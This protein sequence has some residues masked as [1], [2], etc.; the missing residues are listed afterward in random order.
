[1][2]H[3]AQPIHSTHRRRRGTSRAASGL[4][5]L[6]LGILALLGSVGSASAATCV[7]EYCYDS[8]GRLQVALLCGT[9][10]RYT[11]D[12]AGNLI[13]RTVSAGTSPLVC[14]A[15]SDGLPDMA[16]TDT[17]TFASAADTG[18]D[19]FLADTDGDGLV[20][21]V[22]TNTGTFVSPSDTGSD[23]H[24]SDTDDDGVDDGAEVTAGSDPNVAEASV[25]ALG[26]LG[27]RLLMG[28]LGVSGAGLAWRLRRER[29]LGAV[30]LLVLPGLTL[31]APPAHAA[32][33]GPG[34]VTLGVGETKHSEIRAA[35]ADETLGD[36]SYAVVSN[37]AP[38]TISPASQSTSQLV[39]FQIT[40]TGV[41]SGSAQFGWSAPSGVDVQRRKA[42]ET[43]SASGRTPATS[44][45]W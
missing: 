9:E 41:G 10:Y 19:P 35:A 32:V 33:C 13:E 39:R 5:A 8:I 34:A 42:E 44:T 43:M 3:L 26:P 6:W 4:A 29:G 40:G 36:S 45:A 11:Y 31:F 37:T 1:M 23:P 2:L 18:T 12:A 20:D 15:D 38:A 17:G 16:E 22:E 7:E 24:D 25:P 21:S 28:L 14:D 27:S 30:G